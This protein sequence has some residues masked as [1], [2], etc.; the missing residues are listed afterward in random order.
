MAD[1]ADAAETAESE[2]ESK[3]EEVADLTAEQAVA[4]DMVMLLD[5]GESEVLAESI[6]A[7]SGGGDTVV[8]R[9]PSPDS[10]PETDEEAPAP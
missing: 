7:Q 9:R 2:G 3:A 10:E 8:D 6:A 4:A 5:L 1:M